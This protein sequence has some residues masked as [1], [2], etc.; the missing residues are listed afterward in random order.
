LEFKI[1]E[2]EFVQTAY[3][4]PRGL[5]GRLYWYVLVP[6]H[7]FVFR[8]MIGSIIKKAKRSN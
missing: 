6:V 7:Y 3:F 8:N 2:N 5:L 1:Q 4:Y